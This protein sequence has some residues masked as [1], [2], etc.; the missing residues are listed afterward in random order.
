MQKY[1]LLLT[2]LASVNASTQSKIP[3]DRKP[4]AFLTFRFFIVT[5]AL[6][7]G[8]YLNERNAV[9]V[10]YL[11]NALI[12]FTSADMDAEEG[13]VVEYRHYFNTDTAKHTYNRW[14]VSPYYKYR[15]VRF[16]YDEPYGVY[17]QSAYDNSVGILM[18]RQWPFGPH[19]KSVL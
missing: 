8:A 4:T 13:F 2:L 15:Y 3:Y 7:G 6:G 10:Y 9:Q 11:Y 12:K 1:L 19:K 18:G 5:G 14:F 16:G 17:A